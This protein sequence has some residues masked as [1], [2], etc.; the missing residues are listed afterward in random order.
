MKYLCYHTQSIRT[1]TLAVYLQL[2]LKSWAYFIISSADNS[3]FL[4]S[5]RFMFKYAKW[6]VEFALQ[7]MFDVMCN[8]L[9]FS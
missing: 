8:V 3:L 7:L 4:T 9:L 6:M 2:S 5:P 1:S